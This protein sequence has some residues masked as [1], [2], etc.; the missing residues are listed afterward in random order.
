MCPY[1]PFRHAG[2]PLTLENF[3]GVWNSF[4]QYP[5]TKAS[6]N[7]KYLRCKAYNF[8]DICPAMMQ[9]VYDDLEYVDERFCKS[10]T[11][12]Y[13]YYVKQMKF[14]DIISKHKL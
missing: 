11:A 8:C 4:S 9:F 14:S 6:E 7:Y 1:M 13:D 10:A 2:K 5:K 3:K 12:R